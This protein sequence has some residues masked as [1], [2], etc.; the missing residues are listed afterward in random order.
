[1]GNI[2]S[3]KNLS[4]GD[5]FKNLSFNIPEQTFNIL[6]GKNSVGKTTLIYSLLGLVKC[7]GEITFKYGRKSI[8]CVSDYSEITGSVFEYLSKPLINLGYSESRI[9]KTI[10]SIS[11]KLGITNIL[12][13]TNDELTCEERLLVLL[14]HSVIHNPKL[15]II[16]NT[17]DELHTSN[18]IKFINYL[19]GMK[20]TVILVTNDS[21]YFKYSTRLLVMTKTK[22]EIIKDSN[23]ITRLENSLVKNN[24][25]LPFSIELSSKLYSYGIV[26][27]IYSNNSELLDNIWK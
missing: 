2:L 21:R 11:K 3:V 24:S 15:V 25:E 27:E 17:L 8:G 14:T 26:K 22:M 20:I 18:K 16:D 19:R 13:K 12:D 6:I 5:I 4:C 1:M 10:Y 23:S 7:E 9:D